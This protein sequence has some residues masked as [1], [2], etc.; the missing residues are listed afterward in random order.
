MSLFQPEKRVLKFGLMVLVIAVLGIAYL[1]ISGTQKEPADFRGIKWGSGVRDLPDM[2]LLAEDGTLKFYEKANERKKIGEADVDQ[3]VYGFHKDRFYTVMVYYS[4]P[5][6]F[7]RIK[8]TL[9][10][11]FGTPFQANESE[12]KL[13]WNGEHVNLLLNFDDAANTGRIT[14]LFKPIQLEIEVGG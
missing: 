12:K 14:Y 11:A 3:I 5:A 4:F 8:N 2:K 13:F 7:S 9:S 10:S 6:N 1:V